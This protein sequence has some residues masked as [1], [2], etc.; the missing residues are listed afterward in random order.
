M[1]PR[2]NVSSVYGAA[3]RF[4]NREWTG[5]MRIANNGPQARPDQATRNG[6][7]G[8][9]PGWICTVQQRNA[10]LGNP[11]AAGEQAADFNPTSNFRQESCSNAV[12]RCDWLTSSCNQRR[13]SGGCMPI[14]LLEASP[15]ICSPIQ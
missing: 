11:G 6:A 4:F 12:F 5:V 2:Y 7:V 15:Q 13:N 9:P 14:T 8:L 1:G 3:I 10:K